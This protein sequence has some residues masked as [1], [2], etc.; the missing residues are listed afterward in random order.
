[1][2]KRQFFIFKATSCPKSSSSFYL[3]R[4]GRQRLSI[5]E[6]VGVVCSIVNSSQSVLMSS[7][8]PCF[9]L[10][11]KITAAKCIIFPIISRFLKKVGCKKNPISFETFLLQFSNMQSRNTLWQKSN[12]HPKFPWNLMFEKCDF[13]NVNF[14][15]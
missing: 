11:E 8:N 4:T 13:R 9:I 7:K 6:C 5:P 10:F 14:V 12:S 3:S 2:M 15:T 1:M